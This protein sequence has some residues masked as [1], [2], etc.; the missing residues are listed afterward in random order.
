MTDKDLTNHYKQ[1]LEAADMASA[2]PAED[3]AAP[4]PD[5]EPPLEAQPEP[6][7]G[8][9]PEAPAEIPETSAPVT[10]DRQKPMS[11]LPNPHRF[12]FQ[13][14]DEVAFYTEEGDMVTGTIAGDQIS[15]RYNVVDENNTS[16]DIMKNELFFPPGSTLA[17]QASGAQSSA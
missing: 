7:V 4:T 3:E 16:H 6:T 11:F 13:Q 10:A 1:L 15:N 5:G 2:P 8:E 17:E 12:K 9:D 14:G